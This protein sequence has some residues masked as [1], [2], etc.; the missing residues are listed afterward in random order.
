MFSD[1]IPSFWGC[2]KQFKS[3]DGQFSKLRSFLEDPCC[4]GDVTSVGAPSERDPRAP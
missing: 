1:R 2:K 4:E 3:S